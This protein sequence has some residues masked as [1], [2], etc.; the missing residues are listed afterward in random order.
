MKKILY[1]KSTMI[2]LLGVIFLTGCGT[3]APNC[4]SD[5]SKLAVIDIVKEELNPKVALL[6]DYLNNFGQKHGLTYQPKLFN[7]IE[8]SVKNIRTTKIDKE[9][10]SYKCKADL[11]VKLNNNAENVP[12]SFTTEQTDG[13]EGYYIQVFGLSNE[14]QGSL[15]SVL[16][17][18]SDEFEDVIQ[19]SQELT[20]LPKNKIFSRIG[21]LQ[22]SYEIFDDPALNQQFKKLLK[23]DYKV[24]RENISDRSFSINKV[25]GYYYGSG[26]IKHACTIAE[27]AFAVGNNGELFAG[28]ITDGE[29]LKIF[30][31]S[32]V[33]DLPSPLYNWWE[34]LKPNTKPKSVVMGLSASFD[35]KKAETDIEK[36]ICNNSSISNAD[37]QLGILY[38][39][40]KNT[41]PAREFS[42]IKKEQRLWLRQRNNKILNTCQSTKGLDIA[43]VVRIYKR[44]EYELNKIL[45]E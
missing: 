14:E 41:F 37:G 7:K 10:G 9:L 1:I 27:G 21:K 3:S 33:N 15:L 28:L 8:F 13:G 23:S 43:C 36:V 26:C 32:N 45:A 17:V 42:R 5:K 11:S 18:K 34:R 30:G 44:R 12:I 22:F 24:F 16:M 39:K 2:L 29:N 6:E 19:N 31:T 38:K 20:I 35:C 40:I 25:D 4:S